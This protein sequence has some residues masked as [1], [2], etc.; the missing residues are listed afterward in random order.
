MNPIVAIR[1]IDSYDL[2]EVKQA[3]SQFLSSAK[4]ARLSAAKTVL[5]KPNLLGGFSPDKAVT[6]HPVVIEAVIQYLLERKK[7]VWLGDSPG[8]TANLN[9]VWQT[10]GLSALAAKYPVKLVNFSSYGVQEVSL[11]GTTLKISKIAWEADA[12]ISLSKYKTHSMMAF[13]GA[14]KNLYGLVPGLIKSEYHKQNPETGDFA[15]LISTLYKAVKHRVCYHI[16]DGIEGMDG[17]GPSAGNVRQFGLLFGSQSAPAL[18]YIA[19]M[20]MGF[21]LGQVPYLKEVLHYDAILPSRISYPVSFKDY[22][23]A[24]ADIKTAT[25][26]SLALS[27]APSGITF[28]LNRLFNYYPLITADCKKCMVCVKSCPVQTIKVKKD[29]RPYV[30][31]DKCIRCLCCHE[32]CPHHAIIIDKTILARM[33]FRGGGSK[34]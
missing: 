2:A 4:P 6:T 32:M 27:F 12:I 31:R 9:S 15:H 26:R 25:M 20:I 5:I 8:G 13:T 34:S 30:F 11:G 14:V 28:L 3:V 24:D 29:G 21:K 33:I 16:M 7:E 22:R 23:I 1:K 10:C 17:A 19:S 18:D